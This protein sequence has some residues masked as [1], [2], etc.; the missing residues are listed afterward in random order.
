MVTLKVRIIITVI[1]T[2]KTSL[3]TRFIKR[4]LVNIRSLIRIR[5]KGMEIWDLKLANF[6]TEIHARGT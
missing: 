2:K 6:Y 5:C 4:S 1:Q 3:A